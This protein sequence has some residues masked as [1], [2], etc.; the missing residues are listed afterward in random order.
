MEKHADPP[1]M[2]TIIEF[3]SKL[4]IARTTVYNWI[5][6]R[7][8]RP[9]KDF[10]KIGKVI[11]FPWSKEHIA[12]LLELSDQTRDV[13]MVECSTSRPPRKS[14]YNSAINFDY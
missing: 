6:S 12:G 11:R 13:S 5:R 9:G 1:E 8:L 10:L 3:A 14:Q 4:G 7:R 2:L